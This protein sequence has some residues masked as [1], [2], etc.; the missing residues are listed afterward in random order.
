MLRSVRHVDANHDAARR[1]FSFV[2]SGD[3]LDDD[4]CRGR[5]LGMCGGTLT[6]SCAA[7]GCL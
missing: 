1:D 3:V 5:V 2:P 7:D 6:F 4:D